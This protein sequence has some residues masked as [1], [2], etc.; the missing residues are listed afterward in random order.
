MSN[1]FVSL[2][3]TADS[4]FM[5]IIEG[6]Q[7]RDGNQIAIHAPEPLKGITVRAKRFAPLPS[8]M[9]DVL[10]SIGIAL[11][12]QILCAEQAE[13]LRQTLPLNAQTL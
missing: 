6:E 3:D 13:I 7:T 1:F 4:H 2:Y 9:S 5:A 11:R 12:P 8:P 10:A